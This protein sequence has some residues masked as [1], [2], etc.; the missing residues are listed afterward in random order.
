[1]FSIDKRKRDHNNFE[2]NSRQLKKKKYNQK[3]KKLYEQ[4]LNK[5]KLLLNLEEE[6]IKGGN[7]KH[8]LLEHCTTGDYRLHIKYKEN[9]EKDLCEYCNCY[10]TC[11]HNLIIE[12]YIDHSDDE[13]SEYENS[14]ILKIGNFCIE[15]IIVLKKLSNLV[16]K[17]KS[18]EENKQE[19]SDIDSYSFD[20]GQLIADYIYTSDNYVEVCNQI[21]SKCSHN[22]K[23]TNAINDII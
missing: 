23:S 2:S 7:I 6:N 15:K 8:V 20:Y 5:F 4:Y 13:E 10:R 1:M 21:K 22:V 12:E 11:E 18:L 16:Y 9:M 17:M 3:T 14:E 19:M